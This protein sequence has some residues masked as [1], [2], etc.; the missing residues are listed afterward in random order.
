[1]SPAPHPS[2][3]SR[4]VQG[5]LLVPRLD[6]RSIHRE[7]IDEIGAQARHARL[8]LFRAPSGFGKT[9]AMRQYF[10]MAQSQGRA[11]AWLTL[12]ALDDDFR[13]LLVHLVAAFDR[14]LP[15]DEPGSAALSPTADEA[16][17]P[18]ADR[19]AFDLVDR[20][21]HA[22]APFTVFVDDFE[23]TRTHAVDELVRLILDR[24]PPHGQLAIASRRMPAVQVGRLRAQGELVEVEQPHLR[25]T[26]DETA[27]FLLGQA[28]LVLSD[29]DVARLYGATEGWPAALWLAR[30]ALSRR[31]S[32]EAFIRT[33]SGSDTAV[34]EYLA[35]EVLSQMPAD[36]Q[37]FLLRTSVL[38]ELTPEL[39][40]AVCQRSDSAEVL[41]RLEQSSSGAALIDSER[42]L[43][44]YHGMFTSF[45]RAQLDHLAHAEV[46]ELHRRASDWFRSVGRPVPAIEHALAGGD[47]DTA[48]A[49]L[50]EH[51]NSFLF[52]GRFRLLARWLGSLPESA[53]HDRP[54]LRIAHIWA[55][56]FTPNAPQALRR[57]DALETQTA[58]GAQGGS[59]LSSQM[60]QELEALRPYILGVLD[61]HEEGMWL[62]EEALKLRWRPESF[63]FNLLATVAATWRV[64]AARYGEA[65]ELLGRVPAGESTARAPFATL[66]ATCVEGRVD[67][68]QG[69]VREAIA[70]FRV[71]FSEIAASY[72]SR[73]VGKSIAAVFLAEAL[74][75]VDELQEAEQILAL[76]VPIVREF[77]MPDLLIVAHV[78]QA[79]VAFDRGDV[80]HAFRRLTELE[81]IGRHEQLPRALATAQ[82]ER[83]RLALL[84]D[85]IAEAQAHLQRAQAPEAWTGLRGL[86]MPANDVETVEMARWRLA[87]RGVDPVDALAALRT[88]MRAAQSRSRNRRA[89]KQKILLA[90]VLQTN[91]HPRQALR[92]MQEALQW[93]CPQG[94]V[95]AFVDE[96]R[97]VIDLVRE[98]RL[99]HAAA[100][101]GSESDRALLAF[102]DRI[103]RRSGVSIEAPAAN[104]AAGPP[105]AADLGVSLSEREL[106]VLES[107]ARGLPNAA[108]ADAMFVAE[109]TVRAHL[110]KINVKLGA[111]NRTQAVAEARRLGLL[112]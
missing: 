9:T 43:Y 12:D 86:I 10:D 21:E 111:S 37:Q 49:L 51:V 75:E 84:R 5:K 64:A 97:P 107:V 17:A 112:R 108:I 85:D 109:T 7:A 48:L 87:A 29:N 58:Q 61:R 71:A 46:H 65:L 23:A 105:A 32:P 81:Y 80:D 55:L 110:R 52:D 74:Y 101:G 100:A 24:L 35:E 1:M 83:V 25:F 3:A 56:T 31:A 54:H 33:F 69:R 44:R 67:L 22:P 104:S 16:A 106:R 63:A 8:V 18:D 14:V 41:R 98:V 68:L 76:Y 99:G 19:L 103:L 78:I 6:A 72:G 90:C 26:R 102:I 70:Q 92:T 53:L 47:L 39:C 2:G 40:D 57:L 30:T 66:Y 94:L 79:R 59:A 73:S 88:E 45:L 96:G 38:C 4:V 89:F 20:I 13:R 15:A 27:Q 34:A 62:A 95:R 50:D 60:R 91:G 42:R 28:G 36:D 82:L 77:A 11:V 93:A